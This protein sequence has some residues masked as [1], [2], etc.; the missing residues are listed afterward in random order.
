MKLRLIKS[1]LAS[2]LL[3]ASSLAHAL[4]AEA[5]FQQLSPSIWV[6]IAMNAQGKPMGSGS[7]VVIGAGRLVTNCHV[8][9]RASSFKLRRGNVSFP[10]KLEF[11]DVERDLCQVTAEG[12]TAPVVKLAPSRTLRVGQKV[13]TLGAPGALE[14]TIS[15]GLLSALRLDPNGKLRYLQ[16]SAP[17]SVGSSGGGLFNDKGELIGI[18]TAMLA[19]PAVQNLSFA[20][21]ADWILEL[22]ARGRAALASRAGGPKVAAAAPAVTPA[23][24]PV[25]VAPTPAVPATPPPAAPPVASKPVASQP[26]ASQPVAPPPA[27]SPPV[28]TPPVVAAAVVPAPP[29]EKWKG[30]MTCEARPDKGQFHEGYQARFDVEVAGPAVTMRRKNA[31]VAEALTGRA[32]NSRIDLRGVGYRLD[33]P[34]L[35]W[36]FR[37]AGDFP[38]GATIVTAKGSMMVGVKPVRQCEVVITRI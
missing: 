15:D 18:T 16:T 3:V 11:P 38:A 27:A 19:G 31:M 2:L 22:E 17:I 33:N 28:V 1:L 13:F 37:F 29:V 12:L 34:D 4:D 5:L 26:V 30:L 9:A 6:V 36:Q 32:N 23:P 20:V 25:T 21:P 24:A 8:L 10:G 7:A 35:I 14:E